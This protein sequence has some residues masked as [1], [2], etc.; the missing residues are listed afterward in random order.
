MKTLVVFLC[1]FALSC[2]SIYKVPVVKT[3]VVKTIPVHH[4]EYDDIPSHSYV[5]VPSKSYSA[6]Q[7]LG[8]PALLGYHYP[9]KKYTVSYPS[10]IYYGPHGP[11]IYDPK[12][13]DELEQAYYR[14]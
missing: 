9:V 3:V 13:H 4:L 11:G 1:F 7:S 10:G 8:H 6:V 14:G 5:A 2:A 12:F